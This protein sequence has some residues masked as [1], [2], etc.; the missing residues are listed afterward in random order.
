MFNSVKPGSF[1]VKN[2]DNMMFD[3]SVLVNSNTIS[4]VIGNLSTGKCCGPDELATEHYKFCDQRINHMLALFLLQY[5]LM[6]VF[7]LK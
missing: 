7:L 2:L 3:S 4:K 5:L 1:T 6:V